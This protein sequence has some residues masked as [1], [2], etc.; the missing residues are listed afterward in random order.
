MQASLVREPNGKS[1]SPESVA[2]EIRVRGRVQ[3]VGFR[4]TVWRLARKLG[5]CGEVLNDAQGVL[6]RAGGSRRQ[7]AAFVECL[8]NAPPPLAQIEAIET[9]A[10]SGELPEDFR[11]A[12]SVDGAAHTQISPDAAICAAC[13]SET[14]APG[15]RRYRYPFTNCT[16]CGPRLTI[17]QAIPYDRSKTTMAPFAMCDACLEEYFD[18]ADRRF[19]AEPTACRVCGPQAQLIRLDCE[20][21]DSKAQ[22]PAD[23]LEMTANCIRRGEIV[24]IKGLGGY[25]IACDATNEAAVGRLRHRKKRDAKPFA[26]MARDLDI[27]RLYCMPDAGEVRE[28]TSPQAPIVLLRADGKKKLPGG[29]AP[30]LRTLGFMLPTAPLHLILLRDLDFPVVMTSG[31]F[32]DEPPIV[33]DGQARARLGAIATY[34]LIHDRGIANRLDDSVLRVMARK[35]R[36][37]R[38]ARGYAPA[39][40]GLPDGFDA[41]PDILAMGGELKS[42]F[43]LVKDGKAILS[44]HQGDLEHPA[45][46][47]DYRKNLALY[48]DLF[49]HTPTAI[50]AD[51]HP[52]YLSSKLAEQV[53]AESHLPL[54]A[55][56]HHHAHVASCLAENG[57]ALG[58]PRVLGI[59]L[60]GLGF[61]EDGTFWG[62]EFLLADYLGFRRVGALAPVAMPGGTRAIREPWR[63]LY[64]HIDASVGW[65]EFAAQYGQLDLAAA[66]ASKPHATLDAMIRRNIN[67]P[68]AS[69]C[70]RLFDAVAAALGI[71]CEGQAYEGE[72]A[73]RLETL[74][75]EETPPTIQGYTLAIEKSSPDMLIL[76]SRRMW[77]E[78]FRDLIAHLPAS[79]VAARFHK[80]LVRGIVA[81]ANRLASSPGGRC[82][83]TI[84]LSGG[85]FQNRI[86][87]EGVVGEL[88]AEGFAVLAHSRVPANDAGLSLGQAVIA[89]ARLIGAKNISTKGRAQCA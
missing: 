44:Q 61:G 84:A 53:A 26:L 7:I 74:A 47:D 83:E 39:P 18:P 8:K 40:I 63:N 1:Y 86:L 24:A 4:P 11:I 79:V 68:L 67:A 9:R 71:C 65:K 32:S 78:L 37:L 16:H 48:R 36:L 72:A 89:A 73:A 60:D 17:I 57:Y 6:V 80:G 75:D 45:A 77:P 58:A 19:H 33:G 52:E 64:A 15:A 35:P 13:A 62:G 30:G 20:S 82:F 43:C 59:V 41:A 2:V 69:S 42:T 5:L 28:L 14:L 34:A 81:M 23:A 22:G 66:L 38:R 29:I 10:F 21:F 12:E 55:V 50:I 31:N 25:Q 88:T 3:G 70:G 49:G 56:Q 51:R 87:F 85:C 54:I 76:T 27:I 46:F